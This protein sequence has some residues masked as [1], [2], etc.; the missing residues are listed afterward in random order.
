MSAIPPKVDI[1]RRIGTVPR[2]PQTPIG[3]DQPVMRSLR[4]DEASAAPADRIAEGIEG[5]WPTR[6]IAVWASHRIG[7]AV[8]PVHHVA[9]RRPVVARLAVS[10]GA[11]DNGTGDKSAGDARADSAAIAT[12]VGCGRSRHSSRRNNCGRC[13]SKNG[14]F[15]R[16]ASLGLR[17]GRGRPHDDKL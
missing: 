1:R 14:L 17:V 4:A 3:A 15:H 7:F 16:V 11:A 12:G 8:A 13:N 10:N 2:V 9:W 6:P 5:D